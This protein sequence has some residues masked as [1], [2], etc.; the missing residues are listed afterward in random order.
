MSNYNDMTKKDLLAL[1]A[2][3]EIS[4]AKKANKASIVEA[5]EGFDA[6]QPAEAPRKQRPSTKEILR[7]LFAEDGTELSVEDVVAHVL[8]QHQV[9]PATI[10]TMIGDLKNPKYC[11]P[12]GVLNIVR[13][14]ENYVR[15]D[16]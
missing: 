15:R 12:K 16:A 4:I 3:R 14:G 13:E 1:C 2:E 5:L 6:A 11:G 7:E 8:A 9:A 10:G